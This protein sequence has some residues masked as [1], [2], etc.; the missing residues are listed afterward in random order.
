M[1]ND[2]P[3]LSH[4]LSEITQ[5]QGTGQVPPNTLSNNISRIVQTT[6]DFTDQKYGQETT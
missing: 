6:E 2:T 5:T 4:Y 1:P 3:T